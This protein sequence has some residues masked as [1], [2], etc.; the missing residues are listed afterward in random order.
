MA[1]RNRYL[2]AVVLFQAIIGYL[3]LMAGELKLALGF[4]WSPTFFD[5]EDRFADLVKTGLSYRNVVAPNLDASIV[6]RWPEVFRNFYWNNPYGGV[7]ALSSQS[8]SHFHGPPF[9]L[10]VGF[11]TCILSTIPP[12]P[13][14]AVFLCFLLYVVAAWWAGATV[15]EPEKRSLPLLLTGAYMLFFSYPALFMLTRGHFV[16]G[17]CGILI[18]TFLLSTFE[19]GKCTLGALGCLAIAANLRPNVALLALAI[20]ATMGLRASVRPVLVLAAFTVAIFGVSLVIGHWIYPEYTLATFLGSLRSYH[21]IYVLRS[22]GDAFN[23]SLFGLLKTLNYICRVHLGLAVPVSTLTTFSSAVALVLGACTLF[24][25]AIRRLPA[26]TTSFLLLSLLSLST[27]VFAD[28]HLLQFI[29]PIVLVYFELGRS[30]QANLTRS[31]FVIS[32]TCAFLFAP[33]NLLY[34]GISIQRI[35]NPAVVLASTTY[36]LFLIW[37]ARANLPSE[38]AIAS[39]P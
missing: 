24:A 8:L 28:Y 14:V 30:E 17:L 27:P 18:A 31:Q 19:R 11:G 6:E 21:R 13:Y 29:V 25:M 1:P 4:P 16:A 5:P 22:A 12:N 2:L 32:A 26:S 3:F 9:S 34:S 38:G 23:S 10:L 20:P 15:I 33:K 36:V 35:L 39:L 37:R 7:G